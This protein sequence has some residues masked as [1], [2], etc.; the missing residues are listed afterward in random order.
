[1]PVTT[2]VTAI[3]LGEATDLL[4]LGGKLARGA[5]RKRA[6]WARMRWPRVVFGGPWDQTAQP[7]LRCL[8]VPISVTRGWRPV[9]GRIP[10]V[11]VLAATKAGVTWLGWPGSPA[12][13]QRELRIGD[14]PVMLPVA[15]RSERDWK[16]LK[17]GQ[18]VI[19]DYAA[20]VGW[21]FSGF[22]PLPPGAHPLRLVAKAR[23]SKWPSGLYV[24]R[25]PKPEEP[26]AKF[27]L[28]FIE[29][30]QQA[31]VTGPAA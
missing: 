20:M 19:C 8:H 3:S 26:N 24:L 31:L 9:S 11:S 18:A 6:T 16:G 23:A 2:A 7:F 5:W 4:N 22:E 12:Q 13:Q 21:N 28:V 15:I 30:E 14:H 25:C 27:D 1:M 17:A 10:H 29:E